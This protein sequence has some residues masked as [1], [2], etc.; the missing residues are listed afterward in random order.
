MTTRPSTEHLIDHPWSL[1]RSSAPLGAWVVLVLAFAFA[2]PA[3]AYVEAPYTLGRL[4]AESTH[5]V[6]LQVEKVDKEK[7][8]IIYK[9]VQDLKGKHPTDIV[10]HNISPQGFHPREP[11]NI[12]AEAEPG[13]IV[14]MFHN[15]SAAETCMN[16][17]WYQC[18]PG[19][20]WWNLV[21]AEPFLLRSYA[22]KPERLIPL[23]NAILA[24]QEVIAPCYADGDKNALHL[25]TGKLQ[26]LRAS[27][28]LIEYNEK[29]DFVGWGQ[30]E[31]QRIDTMPGF[32][33]L[34]T[35]SRVDPGAV[36]VAAADFDSNG[37]MGL[38]LF[39]EDKT[40]LLRPSGNTM[41]DVPLPY[42]G[43]ARAAAFADIN[44]DGKLDLLL[45]TVTGPKLFINE[46]GKYRDESG[47]LPK[48]PYYNL[49]AVAFVDADVDGKQD[50]LLA[51]G[52]LGLRLYRNLLPKTPTTQPTNQPWFED[53]S[54]KVG[55]GPNGLAANLKGDCL[56]VADVNADGRPD[57]L[58]SAGNGLLVIN[59]PN[60]FVEAKDSGLAFTA[61]HVAPTFS[62]PAGS[63]LFVPQLNGQCR[64]FRN[65]GKAHFADITAQS[66]DLANP[67]AHVTCA[68][69]VDLRKTGRPDLI[70]GR[71]KGPNLY[72]R[73]N[74]NSTFSD[75]TSDIGLY[76]RIFNTRA[77]CAFD[78]N[79][80]G[81]P[82]LAFNNEAQDPV[83]LLGSGSADAQK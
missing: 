7:R 12:M 15:G 21:H 58:Y 57:F 41:E 45:A 54:A 32:S 38:C 53:A 64:L 78:M 2:R 40:V 49:T 23:V 46:G 13:R 17:Y 83:V 34:G 75:A 19:G 9:K 22:G 55:L 59:T 60:G 79:K 6:V 8:L 16:N 48:E 73:N 14:V 35:L 77:L 4:I 52:F 70:L 37:R 42:N 56:A 50:I 29:R 20:D 81:I 43:G 63:L 76:Q 71:I 31:F 1:P 36:G 74:G 51:N 10:R 62:D 33:H 69:W 72:F 30:Q 82:D 27:L 18:Y 67:I 65:D 11:Q 26:R 44:G 3:S 47:R 66:G 28:K 25:R 61:G 24:G 68:L 5:I 39:G 80:D